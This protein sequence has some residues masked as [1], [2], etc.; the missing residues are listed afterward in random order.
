MHGWVREG[1]TCIIIKYQE[2]WSNNSLEGLH[3]IYSLAY[4]YFRHRAMELNKK[5]K[6]R[7]QCI[8]LSTI[9]YTKMGTVISIA[10]NLRERER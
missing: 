10:N 4:I 7:C 9:S 2:E 6:K 5:K 8:K 1:S 3:P